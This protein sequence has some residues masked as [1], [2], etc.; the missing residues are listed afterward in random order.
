MSSQ[1]IT[2]TDQRWSVEASLLF[3]HII[4]LTDAGQQPDVIGMTGLAKDRHGQYR[5]FSALFDF[6]RRQF[7]VYGLTAAPS[8]M[9]V[10]DIYQEEARTIGEKLLREYT[11]KLFQEQ[12]LHMHGRPS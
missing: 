10:D 1:S 3:D 11:A 7:T 2:V 9:A 5:K 4:G 12:L 8:G 6:K